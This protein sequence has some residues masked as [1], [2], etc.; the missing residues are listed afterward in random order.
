MHSENVIFAF[1][2]FQSE[3]YS[4]GVEELMRRIRKADKE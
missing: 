2:L 4:A 3:A 1:I